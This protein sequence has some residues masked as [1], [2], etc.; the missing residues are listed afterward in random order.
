[1]IATQKLMEGMSCILIKAL[2]KAVGSHMYIDLGAIGEQ[3]VW[4]DS[5]EE[6]KGNFGRQSK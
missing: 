2:R 5:N 3:A 4:V 6:Q 1:M